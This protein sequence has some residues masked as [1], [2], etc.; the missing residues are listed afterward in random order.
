MPA[1][2]ISHY[3]TQYANPIQFAQGERV[4]LGERDA[5]WPAF[6]WTTTADGN[7]GWVPT[8]HLERA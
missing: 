4:T 1:R 2:V 8:K 5:E 6:I 7:A 3:R